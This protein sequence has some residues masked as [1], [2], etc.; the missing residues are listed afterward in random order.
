M[1]IEKSAVAGTLESTDAM[2]TITPNQEGDNIEFELNSTVIHQYGNQ[3]RKVVFEVLDR[4]EVEGA[5][6]YVND[7]GALDCTLKARVECAVHRALGQ[8]ENL[9]WGGKIRA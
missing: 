2:V 3:I 8:T 4:L 5:K 1:K 6:V 7:R 9:S